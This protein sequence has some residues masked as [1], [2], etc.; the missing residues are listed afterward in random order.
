VPERLHRSAQT[1]QDVFGWIQ[2]N[3]RISLVTIEPL[4][5]NSALVGPKFFDAFLDFSQA[6]L[7]TMLVRFHFN[8]SVDCH[9][10]RPIFAVNQVIDYFFGRD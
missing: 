9:L 7:G 1:R 5:K 4:T 8:Q 6:A 10:A 2:E 3:R